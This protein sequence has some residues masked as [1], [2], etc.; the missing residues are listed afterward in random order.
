MLAA[1]CAQLNLSV[2]AAERDTEIYR[3][4]RAVQMDYEVL[5]PL[6]FVGVADAVFENSCGPTGYEFVNRD[7]KILMARYLP[8]GLVPTGYPWNNM[9]HQPSLEF[10]LRVRLGELP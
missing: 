8:P 1:L 10:A 3:L 5:R 2:R 9:F 4:P 7:R 6:K